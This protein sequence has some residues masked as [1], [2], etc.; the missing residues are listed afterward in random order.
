MS[1]AFEEKIIRNRSRN[2]KDNDLVEERRRRRRRVERQEQQQ[3]QQQHQ[4]SMGIRVNFAYNHTIRIIIHMRKWNGYFGS[5]VGGGIT[6]SSSININNS[7]N[8]NN[9]S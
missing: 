1:A 8:N 2:R 4:H 9:L 7:Y 3:Y 6:N 5:G